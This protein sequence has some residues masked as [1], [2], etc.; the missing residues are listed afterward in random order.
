MWEAPLKGDVCLRAVSMASVGMFTEKQVGFLEEGCGA[1]D[2]PW[3]NS[4]L[5]QEG[6]PPQPSRQTLCLYQSVCFR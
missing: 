3:I 2:G 5:A 1:R 4:L 6:A